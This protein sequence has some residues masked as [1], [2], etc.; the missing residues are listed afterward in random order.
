MTTLS[1]VNEESFFYYHEAKIRE[2]IED[3]SIQVLSL[4]AMHKRLRVSLGFPVIPVQEMNYFIREPNEI[5]Q[6]DTFRERIL[7]GSVNGGADSYVLS[8]VQNVLA[9]IFVPIETWPD[10]ILLFPAKLVFN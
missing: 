9:P 1:N 2:F 5:L 10:S 6:P 3:P 8:L 7:F 4:Y